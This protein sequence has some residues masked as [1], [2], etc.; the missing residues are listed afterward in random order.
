M[1]PTI[2]L[3]YLYKKYETN[4]ETNIK[5]PSICHSKL[6]IRSPYH[7]NNLLECQTKCEVNG[8]RVVEYWPLQLIVVF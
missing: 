1:E 7:I 3:I 6:T 8:I 2:H 4:Q 5:K